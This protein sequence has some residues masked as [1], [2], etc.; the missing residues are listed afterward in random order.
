MDKTD[1]YFVGTTKNQDFWRKLAQMPG[2]NGIQCKL[3]HHISWRKFKVRG[4]SGILGP[5][6]SSIQL[7]QQW[8]REAH[9]MACG[10]G[11]PINP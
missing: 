8:A 7:I 9:I 2:T 3:M 5:I 4:C 10:P 6:S 11:T 1:V